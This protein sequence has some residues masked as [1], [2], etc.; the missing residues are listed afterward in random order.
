MRLPLSSEWYQKMAVMEAEY[1]SIAAGSPVAEP[2][3]TSVVVRITINGRVYE[4]T[5]DP[6]EAF[7]AVVYGAAREGKV[8][9]VKALGFLAEIG[10]LQYTD[11]QHAAYRLQKIG[12]L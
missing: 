4:G 1:D 8:D 11:P 6:E 10:Y 12:D 2:T 5:L 9:P 3:N 7:M